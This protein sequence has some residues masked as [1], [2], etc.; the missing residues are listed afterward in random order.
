LVSDRGILRNGICPEDEQIRTLADWLTSRRVAE[1]LSTSSLSNQFAPAEA[2]CRAAS[3]L[4]AMGQPGDGIGLMMWFRAEQPET[5]NWAGNPH[6]DMASPGEALTPRASFDIWCETVRGQARRWTVSE[7]EAAQHL[8][9]A[10]IDAQQSLRLRNLNRQLNAT[11]AEKEALLLEK[12]HLLREVNHRVQNSLQLVQAFLALQAQASGEGQLADSLAEA[13]RRLSAVA[14]VHRRLYKGDQIET[15]DLGRYLDE[16]VGDMRSAL[17]PEWDRQLRLD[18]API[19]ISA[20][21]AVNLGLILTEL[22]INANKYAYGGGPGPLEIALEQHA[23]MLR[24]IVADGGSGDGELHQGFG[25]RM[26]NAMI[27]RLD[28][29]IERQDN[30]PGLR[31]IVSA[32]INQD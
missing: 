19:V 30:R 10:L 5:V 25:T 12:D 14:L 21:R 17:G 23:G 4:I 11:L 32:P 2:F 13:Q 22:V 28:G 29:T 20:D 9:R 27:Q 24:L 18:L 8:R 1:T 15:V 6:K 16:L 3:G 26:M 7:V 31:V